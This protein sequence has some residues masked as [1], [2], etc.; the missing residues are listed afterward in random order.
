MFKFLTSKKG[1][2]LIELMITLIL[3][4]LGTF[5]V[6]ALISASRRSFNK[7]EE[8]YEKQETVKNIATV[9]QNVSNIGSATSCALFDSLE[10]LPADGEADDAYSYLFLVPVFDNGDG[11]Y[12]ATYKYN[13]E[14]SS[15]KLKK[16]AGYYI[17]RLNKDGKME[18]KENGELNI[19]CM[20]YGLPL[21]IEFK[22]FIYKAK[23]GEGNITSETIQPAAEIRICAVDDGT[24]F[25]YGNIGTDKAGNTVKSPTTPETEDNI[26][27]ELTVTTH[28]P[29][30][31]NNGSNISL[32][33]V[34]DSVDQNTYKGKVMRLTID[35][36]LAG[37]ESQAKSSVSSFCFIATASYG[38]N[39]G[40]VGLLCD[41]RD[42]IL[43]KN[44]LGKAF[45]KAYYTVSPSVAKVIE[46]SEPLKATVRTALKPCVV[47]AEYALNPDLLKSE[48]PMIS[49]FFVSGLALS[50][51]LVYFNKKRKKSF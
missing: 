27:Y 25:N 48:I 11:T 22:P 23:D 14:I 30:M 50:A 5:A 19:P 28:F 13:D 10:C 16:M 41:F 34:G 8:R 1:F 51:S 44:D 49:L 12:D 32:N 20:N 39:S 46:N 31:V 4:G 36:I 47:V 9:F 40:E 43:L 35:S 2:T 3:L 21:Y 29:N 18:R 37:E 15:A 6:T 45:V 17:Y 7:S 24:Q 38:V 42:N 26:F 33:T